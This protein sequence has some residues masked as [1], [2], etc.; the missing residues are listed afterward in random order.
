MLEMAALRSGALFFCGCD[1]VYRLLLIL[2]AWIGWTGAAHAAPAV[3]AAD[4]LAQLQRRARAMDLAAS[5]TW[6][7][8]L[9]YEADWLGAGVTSTVASD[10]F[11]L[12]ADGRRNPSAE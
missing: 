9:H 3:N 6:R 2:T 7:A 5:P 12:A 10:W 1:R 4:Y 8:L 11:F